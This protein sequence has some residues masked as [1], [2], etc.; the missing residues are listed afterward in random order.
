MLG[1]VRMD[2]HEAWMQGE[3]RVGCV[4]MGLQE[5]TRGLSRSVDKKRLVVR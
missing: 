1:C 2:L 3:E 5:D 4:R